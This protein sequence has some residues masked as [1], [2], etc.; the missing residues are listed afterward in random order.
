MPTLDRR[1]LLRASIALAFPPGV[2][3]LFGGCQRTQVVSSR[4]EPLETGKT[5]DEP[6]E[7]LMQI[8][9]LEIVTPD[10][11]KIC[12]QYSNVHGLIFND[13]DPNLGG[14]RT[15]KL[16][17]GGLLGVRRPLRET[18]SPVVRP[19]VLVDDIEESVAA[20]ADSGA[21]V[22]LPPMD[23][24]GHGICAIVIQGGIECG[25]WQL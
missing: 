2:I 24:Q 6:K 15:A 19:Y 14:A 7:A 9:Y 20:A 10:V 4:D 3:P 17:G 1:N 23:L 12:T 13:P 8:Q 22:A 11:D 21:E 18:E 16:S 5:Y 25:L